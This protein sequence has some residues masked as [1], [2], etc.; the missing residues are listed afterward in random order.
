MSNKIRE[1]EGY[2]SSGSEV[3]YF[4]PNEVWIVGLDEEAP[5][6]EENWFAHCARLHDESDADL[7]DLIEN[8]RKTG[9]VDD[10]IDVVRDGSRVIV[11]DGRRRTRAARIVRKEQAEKRMPIADRVVVRAI[12]RTG[13]PEDLFR[14]NVDSHKK[15]L[16]NPL[17]KARLILNHFKSTGEDAQKTAAFFVVTK[18][19]VR[20]NVRAFDLSQRLQNAVAAGKFPLQEALKLADLPRDEQ[21][22]AYAEL[23]A[24]NATKGA[25]AAQ[26]VE[27]I[28]RGEKPETYTKRVT[29][30]GIFLKKWRAELVKT[31]TYPD[32]VEW[33]DFVLGGPPPKNMGDDHEEILLRAGYNPK[34]EKRKKTEKTPKPEKEKK[35]YSRGKNLKTRNVVENPLEEQEILEDTKDL[36]DLVE[37]NVG[38]PNEIEKFEEIE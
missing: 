21:N 25:G 23:E 28:K 35:E 10:P 27:K 19:V 5:E 20:Y 15:K 14:Y 13:A 22:K 29:R 30:S 6:T 37:F 1:L 4:D 36:E 38:E 9:R 7:A 8:I 12:I 33:L 3:P 31:E 26:G 17:Q 34:S 24:A 11:L 18:S 32:L 16:L 2:K